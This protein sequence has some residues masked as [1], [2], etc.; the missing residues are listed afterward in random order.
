MKRD[1]ASYR[2]R[3]HSADVAELYATRFERGSA[4]GIDRREQRAVR[5]IFSGL[6]KCRTVLD[7]PCGAGRFLKTL[8]ESGRFV[9]GL[10]S[11]RDILAHAQKRAVRLGVR[12]GFIHG[13]ASRLPFATNSVDAIFCNR[14]LHH[15]LKPQER[16][17]FLRD[18]HRVS[19]RHVVVSF[20]DYQKFIGLRLFLKSLKG[21]KPNYKGQPT[22]EQFREEVEACGFEVREVVATGPVWVAQKYFVLR[23]V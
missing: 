2:T 16:A 9:M 4:R 19:R 10:D 22:L 12:A 17:V 13:D 14:L 8:G 15:I 3:M 20:F 6:P 1:T 21:R 5:K 18:L 23:K 7:V 11:G